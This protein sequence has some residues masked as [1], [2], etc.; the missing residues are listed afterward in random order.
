MHEIIEDTPAGESHH[1]SIDLTYS[2]FKGMRDAYQANVDPA[3]VLGEYKN[4]FDPI[5]KALYDA[6]IDEDKERE[7]KVSM[8]TL[9]MFVTPDGY[10]N[11]YFSTR[12]RVMP[13][14]VGVTDEKELEEL[15]ALHQ[16][17]LYGGP[18]EQKG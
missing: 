18:D 15:R 17:A 4:P 9:H 6:W 12:F 10:L 13:S 7:S 5:L 2:E 1:R 11:T 14:L 8:G 16:Q 3:K